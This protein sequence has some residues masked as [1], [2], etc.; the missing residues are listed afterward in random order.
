MGIYDREGVREWGGTRGAH[1]SV[2][3]L[4]VGRAQLASL[5][6]DLALYRGQAAR[7]APEEH[8]PGA[9][10]EEQAAAAALEAAEPTAHRPPPQQRRRGLL[11]RADGTHVEE[12]ELGGR[13]REEVGV[14]VAVERGEELA[15]VQVQLARATEA[16]R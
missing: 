16:A 5:G 12:G 7:L 3:L 10:T 13:S 4:L 9:A 15:L 1:L 8:W 14:G 2:C 11:A 6:L